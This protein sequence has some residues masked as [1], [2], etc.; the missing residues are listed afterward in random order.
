MKVN[1]KNKTMST[2][3]ISSFLY[4]SGFPLNKANYFMFIAKIVKR[5]HFKN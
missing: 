3:K 4:D 1:W 2:C 5:K